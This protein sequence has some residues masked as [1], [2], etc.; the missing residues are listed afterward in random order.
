L[1]AGLI[2]KQVTGK[3]LANAYQT[4]IYS[5]LNLTNTKL[6]SEET[7]GAEVAHHWSVSIGFPKLT[8]WEQLGLSYDAMNSVAWAAGGLY[9]TADDN[10]QFMNGLFNTNKIISDSM[11]VKLKL[12]EI[13]EVEQVMDWVYFH[14]ITL[15]G[16]PYTDMA[17]PM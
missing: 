10:A 16:A 14:T 11:L 4:Y 3:S 13:L 17:E 7:T 5:P 9:A 1:L 6:L 12:P 15:M 2:I 8:D